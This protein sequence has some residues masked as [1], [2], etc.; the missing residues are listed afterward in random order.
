MTAVARNISTDRDRELVRYIAE[1]QVRR[2]LA[3]FEGIYDAY[4]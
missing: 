4:A 1:N 2:K 3:K